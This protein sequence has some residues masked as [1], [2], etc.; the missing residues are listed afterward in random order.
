MVITADLDPANSGSI[1]DM[2]FK[3]NGGHTDPPRFFFSLNSSL[4]PVK[5]VETALWLHCL[6]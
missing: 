1:P 5:R 4:N 3:K 2:S 6:L